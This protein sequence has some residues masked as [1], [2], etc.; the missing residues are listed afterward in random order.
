MKPKTLSQFVEAN[1]WSAK[2]FV[3][4]VRELVPVLQACEWNVQ[5]F[6]TFVALTKGLVKFRVY[7]HYQGRSRDTASFLNMSSRIVT[8]FN[9]SATS[10]EIVKWI[11]VQTNESD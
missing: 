4:L 2:K 7:C 10:A 6:R 9:C 8:D 3:P 11:N 5:F 1:G